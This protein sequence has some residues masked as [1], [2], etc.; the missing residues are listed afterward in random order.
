VNP[1][2]DLQPAIGNR[3]VQRI[4]QSDAEELEARPTAATSPRLAHDFSRI[5]LY[6]PAVNLRQLNSAINKP[7]D[8]SERQSNRISGQVI[9]MPGAQFGRAAVGAGGVRS[10]QTEQPDDNHERSDTRHIGRSDLSRSAVPPI[11]YE[12]LRSPGKS[13]DAA[14]RAF[15][16]PRFAYDFSQVRV[17][18]DAK[19]AESA[20]AVN[21]L[22]Y[23]VGRDL[24]FGEGQYAPGAPGARRLLAHE[25]THVVQQHAV[26]KVEPTFIGGPSDRFEREADDVSTTIADM[27]LAPVGA[28]SASIEVVANPSM[29]AGAIQRQTP[30]AEEV[31]RQEE[32]VWPQVEEVSSDKPLTKLARD[33]RK[34]HLKWQ[35]LS[36][37]DRFTVQKE[38]ER[39]YGKTFADRFLEIAQHGKPQFGVKYFQP[40]TGPTP[41]KLNEGLWRFMGMEITGA[42]DIS[43]QLW[44]YPS[45]DIT[46][47]DVSTRAKKEEEPTEIVEPPKSLREKFEDIKHWLWLAMGDFDTNVASLESNPSGADRPPIEKSYRTVDGLM[48][49]LLDLED[50]AEHADDQSLADEIT[51]E[52]VNASH[53][54]N[55]I[56]NRYKA[57]LKK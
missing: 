14:V 52:Y 47:R 28:S 26:G 1:I 25:L 39:F 31:T 10:F 56:N 49:Q 38:M 16:E 21:A 27:G 6:P 3:A 9:Q 53:Q 57:F 17:H 15:M 29:L 46:R 33:P 55:D 43:V 40:G 23:T 51:A 42:A 36:K 32:E 34:A 50:E 44:V 54:L 24:V 4:P 37:E 13:L 45:G 8:E 19:A 7:E 5:P 30:R 35:R 20:C 11:V 12:V 22:A 41:E 48:R 18:T 2:V